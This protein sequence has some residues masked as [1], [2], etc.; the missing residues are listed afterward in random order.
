[1]A[2]SDYLILG[3]GVFGVSTAYRLIKKY[4][5]ASIT[6]VDRDA[7]DAE[8]RVAASWDW[9]KVV[10]ADYSD[11]DYCRLAL[12]AQ[13]VFK[14][15]PLWSPYFHE[16]GIF[17]T[18][19]DEFSGE[20]IDNYRKLGRKADLKAV[21]VAEAKHMYGGV[22]DQADYSGVKEVLIN[23]TS[24]WA[25][26]GDCLGAVT[27]ETLRLGVRYVVADVGVLEFDSQ[28]ECTGVQ[29]VKG[30]SLKAKRVILATGAYTAK[31]LELSAQKSGRKG[32]SAEGKIV[33][34]GITTGKTRL[35]DEDYRH[36]AA[37]PVGVQGYTAETGEP[38]CILATRPSI[39]VY[40]QRNLL[41][42]S[43]PSHQ[44]HSLA[45]SHRQ[46]SVSSSG[47]ARLS[48]ATHAPSHLAPAPASQCHLQK[49]ITLSGRSL[50][51]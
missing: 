47:G 29:T 44:V 37:M 35:N 34:G 15:D 18:C 45:L 41:T 23:R 17:W 20:V 50:R 7:F 42:N 11:V 27:R 6:L 24:G 49:Q 48:S 33:A 2:S 32:L 3:A 38:L 26:A 43:A 25:A 16:T 36:F 19:R 31:L 40:F 4:P 12:E 28:G 1:M 5:N 46:K 13:D 39:I 22:F 8:T 14:T 10:R 30:E 9:N 51:G 21:S